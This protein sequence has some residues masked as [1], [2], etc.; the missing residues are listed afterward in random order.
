MSDRVLSSSNWRRSFAT[1]RSTVAR[2]GELGTPGKGRLQQ[3]GLGQ[4]R[5]PGIGRGRFGGFRRGV[6]ETRAW[7]LRAWRRYR[8]R[9][10][11]AGLDARM[12]RDIGV[13]YAEAEDEANKPFWRV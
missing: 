10:G 12:L 3:G 2:Q 7:L 9:Q 5:L 13:S 1:P 11:I 6:G 4:V 8:S